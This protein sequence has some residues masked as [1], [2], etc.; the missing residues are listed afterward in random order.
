MDSSHHSDYCNC[1]VRFGAGFNMAYL[2]KISHENKE[3]SA[4]RDELKFKSIE[5]Y[6]EY[7]LNPSNRVKPYKQLEQL[8]KAKEKGL[9][10]SY[11]EN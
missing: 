7:C 5:M 9:L 6:L 8:V 2:T 3:L 4:N 1:P 11:L 10:R